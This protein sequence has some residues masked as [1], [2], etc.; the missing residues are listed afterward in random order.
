M[1]DFTIAVELVLKNEGGFVAHPADRGGPTN[2]G[3]S[4]RQYPELRDLATLTKEQAIELY[5]R[6]YWQPE[7]NR[8]ALQTMADKLFDSCVNVG[9]T[10]AVT[11]LQQ[12]L[13]DIRFAVTIDGI[14]GPQTLQ[15]LNLV[16]QKYTKSLLD[17][18]RARQARYYVDI[19]LHDRTQ[20]VFLDGWLRRAVA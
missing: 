15:A 16:C 20:V 18:W 13:G 9:K 12:A 1:A 3:L 11:L 10:R 4:Q 5:R 2:F 19:V 6:D 17:A 8:I 14:F 7:F